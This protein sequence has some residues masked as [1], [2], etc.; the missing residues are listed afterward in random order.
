MYVHK[1]NI[2][3]KLLFHLILFH[4]DLT[5]PQRYPIVLLCTLFMDSGL[6]S[7]PSQ[8]V[9]LVFKCSLVHTRPPGTAAD[10]ESTYWANHV[11][12]MLHDAQGPGKKKKNPISFHCERSCCKIVDFIF[13]ITILSNDSLQC[14]NLILSVQYH[15]KV[16]TSHRIQ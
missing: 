16:D 9:L 8:N 11:I 12:T 7:L 14:R 5:D 10:F 6:P 4:K 1:L 15:L 3:V 13:S 2:K